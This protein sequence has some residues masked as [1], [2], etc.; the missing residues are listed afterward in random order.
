MA[1]LSDIWSGRHGCV[2]EAKLTRLS[3]TLARHHRSFDEAASRQQGTAD[4]SATRS[5]R[6][7]RPLASP[8]AADTCPLWHKTT[9]IIHRTG[10][11]QAA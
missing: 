3:R 6:R 5:T 8:E 10:A 11:L 4:I 1:N 9:I 2:Q 7:E